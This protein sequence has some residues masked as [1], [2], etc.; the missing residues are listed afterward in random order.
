MIRGPLDD[1]KAHTFQKDP[2]LRDVSRYAGSFLSF[3]MTNGEHDCF[4]LNTLVILRNAAKKDPALRRKPN[5][6]R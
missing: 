4:F 3:R 2:V 5:I 1:G 6:D